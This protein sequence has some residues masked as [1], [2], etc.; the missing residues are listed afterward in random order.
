M[1]SACKSCSSCCSLRSSTS[2]LTCSSPSSSTS[3][4]ICSSSSAGTANSSHWRTCQPFPIFSGTRW[5]AGFYQGFHEKTHQPFRKKRDMT[6]AFRSQNNMQEVHSDHRIVDP[7]LQTLAEKTCTQKYSDRLAHVFG[8]CTRLCMHKSSVARRDFG[9]NGSDTHARSLCSSCNIR[10]H[11]LRRGCQILCI[12]EEC[13]GSS[14]LSKWSFKKIPEVPEEFRVSRGNPASQRG[15]VLGLRIL[16][17][18]SRTCV[19]PELLP[20]SAS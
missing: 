8:C 10:S 9:I 6:N 17:V 3:S 19:A 5:N 18:L 2:S 20:D 11:F 4:S 12:V 7:I 14:F 1:T 15:K 13:R 16:E